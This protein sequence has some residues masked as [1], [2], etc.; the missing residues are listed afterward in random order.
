MAYIFF[1]ES[2]DLGFYFKNEKTTKYFLIS[3][4]IKTPPEEKCL[5]IVG[6]LSWILFRK[7]EDGDESYSNIFKSK[8]I[9]EK[10]F[11]S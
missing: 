7:H 2:G 11:F 10:S 8:I 6:M 9:E 3:I 4:E 5:Q 1:D